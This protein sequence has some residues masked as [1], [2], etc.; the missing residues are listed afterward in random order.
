MVSCLK[1]GRDT[2]EGAV[3]CET[4]LADMQAH[5]VRPGTPVVLPNRSGEPPK[6]S[7]KRRGPSPEDQLRAVKRR[8]RVYAALW[9]V[10][11]CAMG[12]LTAVVWCS[13]AHPTFRPGQNYTS[14]VST[15]TPTDSSEETVPSQGS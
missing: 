3:F 5:P 12:V 8:V 6:R 15:T 9:L 13:R 10:T 2:A 7:P 11:L 4:C 14:I 1:C